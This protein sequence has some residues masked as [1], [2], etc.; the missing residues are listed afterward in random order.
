MIVTRQV[1]W[2]KLPFEHATFDPVQGVTTVTLPMETLLSSRNPQDNIQIQPND[3]ISVPKA[4]IVYV[5]GNV[6]KSGGFTLPTH[7]SVSLL[8]ALSLAEGLDQ[9]AKGSKARIL[10]PAPNG[11]GK[12]IDIPVDIAKITRGEAKDIPMFANDILFVPN[13]T[14]RQNAQRVT[15]AALAVTTGLIIYRR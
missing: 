1:K 13:S 3:I 7:G 6:H 14:I 12:A 11:D 2:G 4:D 8:Q 9:N 10:R 5:L 15:D